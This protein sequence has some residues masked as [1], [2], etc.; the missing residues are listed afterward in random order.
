MV[1]RW[2]GRFTIF[3]SCKLVW[4]KQS[5][6]I[7]DSIFTRRNTEDFVFVLAGAAYYQYDPT[8][9]GREII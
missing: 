1:L 3:K 5:S 7:D 8:K 4:S 9:N 6:F 2:T